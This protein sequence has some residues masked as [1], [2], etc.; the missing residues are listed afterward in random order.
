MHHAASAIQYKEKEF[1]EHAGIILVEDY[2]KIEKGTCYLFIHSDQLRG[3]VLEKW[4]NLWD[5]LVE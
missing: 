1:I 2:L 3:C 4:F 5:T